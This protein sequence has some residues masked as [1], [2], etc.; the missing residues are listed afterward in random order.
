M[1]CTK[2]NNPMHMTRYSDFFLSFHAWH[3]LICGNVLDRTIATNRLNSKVGLQFDKAFFLRRE[4][5]AEKRL[6]VRRK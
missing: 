2:C 6:S 3:C 4:R 5:N 1:N